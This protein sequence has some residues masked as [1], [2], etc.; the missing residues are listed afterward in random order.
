MYCSLAAEN[1]LIVLGR[2]RLKVVTFDFVA[3]VIEDFCD[4]E[5]AQRVVDISASLTMLPLGP[6]GPSIPVTP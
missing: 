3:A 4:F 5:H 6:E 2:K 1:P